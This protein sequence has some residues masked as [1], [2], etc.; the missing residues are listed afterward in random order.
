MIFCPNARRNPRAALLASV[1]AL[2]LLAGCNDDGTFDSF[3]KDDPFDRQQNLTRDDYRDINRAEKLLPN[4]AVSSV[5]LGAP[6]IPDVAQVIAAPM[7]PKVGNTKRVSIAVTDDVP[8]RDVLFELGR[9]ANVDI[10]IG[11]GLD[12]RGV[13]LRAQDRPF[14]EVI[15]RIAD[16]AGLRY[17]VKNGALRVEEDTP[18]VKN[19]SID[20]LNAERSGTS[21]IRARCKQW[22]K[23][24]KHHNS[25]ILK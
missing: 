18:Y 5:A 20:F 14:N 8:L 22:N 2:S 17:S 21:T 23:H 9:L 24:Q 12:T 15:E 3:R 13:N 11:P 6:P 10:E 19:Y 4:E 16:L 25:Q 7:P 1:L